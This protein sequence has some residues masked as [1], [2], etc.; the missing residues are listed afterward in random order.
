MKKK[1]ID[2]IASKEFK[3][4]AKMLLIVVVLLSFFVYLFFEVVFYIKDNMQM[5]K[6]PFIRE[7]S[8][9]VINGSANDTGQKKVI[10]V[11]NITIT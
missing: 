6:K 7:S 8:A 1:L 2:R 11:G 5:I 3:R 9:D 10:P 4:A